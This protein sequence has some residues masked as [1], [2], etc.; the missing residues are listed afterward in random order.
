M[1]MKLM[2][3]IYL[4]N[5][6]FKIYSNLLK[7]IKFWLIKASVTKNGVIFFKEMIGIVF[8]VLDNYNL[9]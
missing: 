9:Q 2:N 8:V 6:I 3:K 7:V 4:V 1:T 5:K